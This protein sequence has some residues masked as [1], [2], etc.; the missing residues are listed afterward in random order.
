MASDCLF[1]AK[2]LSKDAAYHAWAA[3]YLTSMGKA[4][5]DDVA[6]VLERGYEVASG[7]TAGEAE[8]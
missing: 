6:K 3:P 1:L 2:A 4:L 8:E 7:R 5:I